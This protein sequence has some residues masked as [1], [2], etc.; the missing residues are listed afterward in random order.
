MNDEQQTEAP[1][2]RP[3]GRPRK[4][5]SHVKRQPMRSGSDDP[6]PLQNFE[7]KPYEQENPLAIDPDIVR[8]IEKE[9]GY[10]LLWVCYECN[11]KPFPNLV[12]A[13]KRNG[14][15]E[16]RK[17]N[18]GGALDH[19]T[20]KNDGGIRHEGLILMA[21]PVEIQ[22]LAKQHDARAAKAAIE[23]MRRSHSEEGLSNISMPDGNNPV[24][25]SRPSSTTRNL[26]TWPM[27]RRCH[28]RPPDPRLNYELDWTRRML[29]VKSRHRGTS[30]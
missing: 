24:A 17:G 23:N 22:K 7:Y 21:R 27:S 8:S 15:A 30:A 28:F 2:K 3:P 6:D 12:S 19:L 9:W 11:G 20:D 5:P 1:A 10:S 4:A 16:V 26:K 14:Y 25:K 18:F 13:R 29:W